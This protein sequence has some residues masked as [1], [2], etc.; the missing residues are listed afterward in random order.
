MRAN[1]AGREALGRV[2]R[3]VMPRGRIRLAADAA[4]G[5]IQH[6]VGEAWL[7]TA[8][9]T[10]D[11]VLQITRAA[12]RRPQFGSGGAQQGAQHRIQPVQG[13]TGCKMGGDEGPS[14]SP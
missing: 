9:E 10:G 6:A 4:P 8:E 5:S 7:L 14:V 3:A 11:P 1:S 12:V 2:G 13:P